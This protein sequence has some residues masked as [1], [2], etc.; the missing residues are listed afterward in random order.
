MDQHVARLIVVDQKAEPASHVEPF[1]DAF[2]VRFVSQRRT[3]DGFS[4]RL[5]RPFLFFCLR[6]YAHTYPLPRRFITSV[7]DSQESRRS[8]RS[9]FNPDQSA[10]SVKSSPGFML[11]MRRAKV[12]ECPA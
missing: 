5:W 2:M 1:D 6:I 9:R 7:R 11:A 8:F 10:R 4:R 12:G 3:G